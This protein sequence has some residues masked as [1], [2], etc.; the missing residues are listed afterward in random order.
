M[1][2]D[3]LK[4]LVT[5]HDQ[6]ST[7]MDPGSLAMPS[8][9]AVDDLVSSLRVKWSE[10]CI[11]GLLQYPRVYSALSAVTGSF[12][13]LGPLPQEAVAGCFGQRDERHWPLR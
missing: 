11:I 9:S 5:D 8:R 1:V 2:T 12:V 4:D 6:F 7:S 13:V 10:S 3:R